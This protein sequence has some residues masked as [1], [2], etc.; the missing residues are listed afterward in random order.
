MVVK[1]LISGNSAGDLR[2]YH[3]IKLKKKK[4]GNCVRVAILIFTCYY[5][6]TL[7]VIE[8]FN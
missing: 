5:L 7:G 4:N 2:N 3:L 1:K 8:S 6:I